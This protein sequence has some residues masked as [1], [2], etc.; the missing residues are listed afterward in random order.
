MM[1]LPWSTAEDGEQGRDGSA[2]AADL[3][4]FGGQQREPRIEVG[5][6]K[7]LILASC[8]LLLGLPAQALEVRVHISGCL[9]GPPYWWSMQLRPANRG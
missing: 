2:L 8:A 3:G 7:A 1:N 5:R 4:V 6:M 9:P